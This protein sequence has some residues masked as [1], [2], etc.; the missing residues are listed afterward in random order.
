MSALKNRI[1]FATGSSRGI[2]AASANVFARDGANVVVHGRDIEAL[3]SVRHDIE[4]AG[5]PH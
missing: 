3:A 1:A 5:G 4:A 2:G